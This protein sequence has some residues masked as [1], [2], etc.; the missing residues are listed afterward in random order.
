MSSGSNKYDVVI[1]GAGIA[2]ASLAYFLSKHKV[3]AVLIDAKP[4]E[5]VGDK[6]CGDAMGRHHF[7]EL[8]IRYPEGE[9]VEG[10]VKGIDV[11]SPSE[12]VRFRVLG[13]GFEI[14]R[15][16]FTRRFINE[17]QK[18]GG[19]YLPE[20]HVVGVIIK[21]GRV[22]GVKTWSRERGSEEFL[23]DLVVDATGN[24][25]AV[26][27][28]LPKRWPIVDEARP[29]EFNIAYREI[30]ELTKEVEEPEYLRIY[31][32]LE[33]APGGY[34]WFFPYSLKGNVVN[35]GLGVQGGRGYPHPK[36]LLYGKV[37]KRPEFEGS[38][39]IETG[40]AAVPTRRPNATLVWEGVAVVG[41]AAYT[42]NPIHGGGK[43]S[44]MISSYCV[45]KAYSEALDSGA[46]DL[47]GMWPSNRCYVEMYGA[48]QAALDIFRQFLQVL[49]NEDL[50]F[51]M[52]S[53]LITEEDLNEVSLKGELELSIVEKAMRLIAGLRRPSLL[54]KLRS[55]AKYM[56]L[57]RNHYLNYPQEPS[58]LSKWLSELERI[59]SE[60]KVKVLG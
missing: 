25:R 35:V 19:T 10:V 34:W 30:R 49:S 31:L 24:S 53:K 52:K 4:Y 56:Q 13:E 39:V 40:G 51:S 8:D 20:T 21:E 9:E 12:E 11:Y 45:A 26:I 6:P 43:G 23:A 28:R 2:G 27:R 22:A 16:E 7:D 42:V 33:V 17:F 48:K 5:R 50:E 38:K 32:N 57:I 54:S 1:A 55:V 47:K 14:N 29:D 15:V 37:L 18:R 46:V 41:D 3:N 60:F 44:A 59:Y 36:D 58:G